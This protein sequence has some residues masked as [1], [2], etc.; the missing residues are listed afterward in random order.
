MATEPTSPSAVD[1]AGRVVT[2]AG[3]AEPQRSRT[4]E[5]AGTRQ[6]R[7]GW[8]WVV[9]TVALFLSLFHLY[10]GY[11]GTLPDLQ[12][13]APHLALGLVLVFLLYPARP[14]ETTR[15][16]WFGWG[17]TAAGAALL[18]YLAATG[19][20]EWYV[21][22][23]SLG[24]LVV[25][26][27][28]R[29]LPWSLLGVPAGDLVLSLLGLL[30]G[31][32]MFFSHEEIL[33]TAGLIAPDS[34]AVATVG[35]LLV[36]VATQRVLGTALVVLA[37]AMLAYAYFGPFLPGFLFHS[38]YTLDRIISTV[39]L[40]TEGVFGTPIG[41]SAT[42][43]FLFLIF[44]AMLQ[45]TGMERFFTDLALG[46][47]GWATGGTA[48]VG[49]VTSAFTGTITG[50]SVANTVSNGAFTIPMMKRSGYRS[51]YAGA[52]EAASSTGG[53]LAPP[54]MGAAAFI[55][56]EFT[57]LAYIQIIV[58]AAVPAVLFFAAQFVVIHFDSKRLGIR[59]IPRREL[60]DLRHLLASKG[61]LLLPIVGIF[62][63]LSVGYSPIFAAMG[64]IA[65]TVGVNALAQVVTAALR[66]WHGMDDKLTPWSLLEGLVDA[67]RIAL[68]IIIACATA[69]MIAGVITLTGLG[70]KLSNG[71]V[72]LGQGML[73]PTMVLSMLACLILGI[74]LPT[75]ANYVITATLAAPAIITI[76]QQDASEPTTA[77]LLMAHLFVYY[78][79]VMADI[80]PPVCL[81]AYAASGVSGGNPIRTGVQS[82]RIAVSGF[83][84]PFMFVLSPELL[85][86]G[87]TWAS[88]TL[89]VGTGLL[90]ASLVGVAVV[91]YVNAPI[92]WILRIP[93]AGAG[94]ALLHGDWRADL[95]GGAVAALVLARHWW[96]S[97]STGGGSVS[98]R[99]GAADGARG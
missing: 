81:A 83:V 54:I 16:R 33:E 72:T 37:G 59:G 4:A 86:Q 70:L 30:C 48:K 60:P 95:V 80:T 90:G 47:T 99:V 8:R 49:V 24:V 44:A 94:L 36:L 46:S 28:V 19:V 51:E 22:A 15:Q 42:F 92:S 89:A 29:Y 78:F 64:A 17:L 91:G 62:T 63:L 85:L 82:V 71:L 84:V 13:R 45:R 55:M 41:I 50:S 88:G 21:L 69:G 31:A 7:V 75:T 20:A 68:P 58:A 25:V 38:G 67:A 23:P 56:I 18:A 11:T 35:I 97:R 34:V 93:V 1:S 43:I 87:V 12:Q 65:L 10:T 73:L 57:G 32:Y 3:D 9:F 26:Q 5:P 2:G 66:R 27:A 98:T 61:Y 52:V 14:R 96:T 53:Q 39:F 6:L 40:G 77:M 74:G 79:G 76:L